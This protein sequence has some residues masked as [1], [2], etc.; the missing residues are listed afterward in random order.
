MSILIP[1]SFM[2]LVGYLATLYVN[3]KK[4]KRN[5]KTTIGTDDSNR[6]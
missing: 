1:I 2:I 6:T 5:E 3:Y 4:E